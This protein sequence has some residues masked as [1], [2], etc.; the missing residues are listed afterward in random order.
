MKLN[1][2]AHLRNFNW[3]TTKSSGF[4]TEEG[5]NSWIIW[6]DFCRKQHENKINWRGRPNRPLESANDKSRLQ[7]RLTRVFQLYQHLK[8]ETLNRLNISIWL[9]QAQGIPLPEDDDVFSSPVIV[10]T[11][12]SGIPLSSS[13]AISDLP[14][15][16][17]KDSPS[18][19][20]DV[21]NHQGNQETSE[22]EKPNR[23][24]SFA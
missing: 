17:P 8:V 20:D 2:S 11:E 14:S 7:Y 3:L 23:K 16:E 12:E 1:Y 21:D 9:F 10:V 22:A 24:I 13:D 15:N 18:D 4:R 5:G 19:N 6:Q